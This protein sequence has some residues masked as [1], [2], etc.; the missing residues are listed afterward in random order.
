MLCRALL[1]TLPR[2][3]DHPFENGFDLTL[4]P[5]RLTQPLS[6]QAP[7]R[8]FVNSMS[9]L[10]HKEVPRSFIDKVFDT[11]EKANWHTFQVLTKRSSLSTAIS[12]SGILLAWPRRISGWAFRWRTRR[13]LYASSI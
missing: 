8:I 7:R 6:W 5:A 12:I 11:M 2:R 4:R 10:F 3:P 13:M 1:R 9:D